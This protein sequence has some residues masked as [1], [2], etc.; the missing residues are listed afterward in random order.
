[1]AIL[2]SK[3]IV[4]IPFNN[5][6]IYSSSQ[7]DIR[8]LCLSRWFHYSSKDKSP[9]S[10]MIEATMP[11]MFVSLPRS[12]IDRATRTVDASDILAAMGTKCFGLT[13]EF[14]TG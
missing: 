2:I 7:P 13:K 12:Q 1:M 3:G 5:N 11:T 14:M 4:S 10:G 8:T 9:R 6:C